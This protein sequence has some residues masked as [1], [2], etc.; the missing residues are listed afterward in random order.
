[1]HPVRARPPRRFTA[2][3][4]FGV[5]LAGL[6]LHG[7]VP[8][9]QNYIDGRAAFDRGDYGTAEQKLLA[10]LNAR[11]ASP[12][13]SPSVTYVSQ[14]RGEFRPEY[15]LALIS[16]NQRKCREAVSFAKTAQGYIGR[17]GAADA[18]TLAAAR[19]E[20]DK[21]LAPP[22]TPGP[23]APPTPTPT[24]VPKPTAAATAAPPPPVTAPPPTSTPAPVTPEPGGPPG[25]SRADRRTRQERLGLRAF[26]S[27][28]YAAALV[29][30]E[31]V[32]GDLVTPRILFYEACS[33]AALGLLGADS[34]ASHLQNARALFVRSRPAQNRFTLDRRYISPRI[35]QALQSATP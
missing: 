34:A 5:L 35:L 18:A 3:L 23:T 28:D 31:Q 4:A 32:P 24:P 14:Q 10:S 8:W 29:A 11:D 33:H 22:P 30:L 26:Y 15:Y 21:C 7:Q 16:L 6:R 20:I 25:E 19:R 27:G 1:M 9:W 2:A 17:F 12:G 13:R